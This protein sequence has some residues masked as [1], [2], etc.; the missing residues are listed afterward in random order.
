MPHDYSGLPP[1]HVRR[2]DRAVT[3]DGWI[4]SLLRTAPSGSFATVHDGRPY[5]NA[6]LFVFDEQAHA[7]YFH[8]ARAGRTAGNVRSDESGAPA[9]FSTFRMGRML[10]AATALGFSVE[11]EGVSVFGVVK[12]LEDAQASRDALQ[13]L[14]DKYA[15]HLRPGRDYRPITDEEL[16]RTAVYRMDIEC[17]SGK[18]KSEPPDFPG[19]FEYEPGAFEYERQP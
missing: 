15:P 3:D 4:R 2:R 6:N 5:I 8:T 14:L 13:A 1:N 18:R 19:A 16:E 10:P 11:Y 17:W 12:I 7:L 9:C